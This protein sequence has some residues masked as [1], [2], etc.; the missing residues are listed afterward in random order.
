MIVL[1]GHEGF[2]GQNLWN[3][4]ANK[5]TL[6]GIEQADCWEKLKTIPWD[7]VSQIHHLGAISDTT[8]TDVNLVYDK[9]IK[10][11]IALFEIAI[12]FGIPVTYASSASVYGNSES[13]HTIN[14]LNY[15]ALSKA[16]V[17]YWV[18]DNLYKFV[19]VRGLRFYNVY[20]KY[21][22]HKGKQASPVH[23]FTKQA[24][25]TGVIKLFEG[26]DNYLRDFIWVEDCLDCLLESKA[27]GIYDVGTGNPISFT[28]VAELVAEKYSAE[29]E[30]I[31][32]PAHLLNKYQTYTCAINHYEKDFT[33]VEKYLSY[34]SDSVN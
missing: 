16:T 34:N 14:P 9:N 23:Q 25:E 30:I 20:G 18:Q 31:P 26:S 6:I 21:E 27:S 4:L 22:D 15:Y 11:S 1:T 29:I 19:N 10:F 13:N 28:E 32:F 3:R 24:K 5:R 8:V 7:E 33:S 12:A 2:I 17:D